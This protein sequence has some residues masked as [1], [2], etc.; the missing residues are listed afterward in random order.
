[1]QGWRSELNRRVSSPA[2]TPL[3]LAFS[4]SDVSASRV[5][6]RLCKFGRPWIPLV[7]IVQ[8]VREQVCWD[9]ADLRSSAAA[10]VCRSGRASDPQ[11]DG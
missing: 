11:H 10:R 6:V 7:T 3:C 4:S 8:R 5:S 9:G 2:L 1:M